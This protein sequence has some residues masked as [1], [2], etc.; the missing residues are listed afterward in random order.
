MQSANSGGY[1]MEIGVVLVLGIPDDPDHPILYTQKTSL[2][3]A[4]PEGQVT[5]S[6]V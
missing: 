4:K 5:K 1:L 3:L 6:G 2:Q